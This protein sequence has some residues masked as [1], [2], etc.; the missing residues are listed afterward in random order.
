M[1]KKEENNFPF[2]KYLI[3]DDDIVIDY[4]S[5]LDKDT[6]YNIKHFYEDK[7]D[8]NINILGD[9]DEIVEKR[10]LLDKSQLKVIKNILTK[11]VSLTQGPPGTGKTFVGAI[12]VKTLLENKKFQGP[13][14]VVWYNK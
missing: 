4:P 2:K 10:L 6:T 8:Q 12:A 3:Y 7:M 14:L 1:K 11:E 13:I 9:W 5:Y